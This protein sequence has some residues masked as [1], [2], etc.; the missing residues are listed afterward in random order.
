MMARRFWILLLIL[1]SVNFTGC[2][3]SKLETPSQPEI[4]LEVERRSPLEQNKEHILTSLIEDEKLREVWFYLYQKTEMFPFSKNMELCGRDLAMYVIENRIP[5]ILSDHPPCS[6]VGCSRISC[7]GEVC[8]YENKTGIKPI[9]FR[10]FGNSPDNSEFAFLV[11]TMAHEIFHRMQLFGQVDVTQFEEFLAFFVGTRVSGSIWGEFED[12]DPLQPAC[13]R[14]WFREH[15]LDFY[16]T[17]EAYP[18]LVIETL[19]EDVQNPTCSLSGDLKFTTDEFG[20]PDYQTIS[21]G[22]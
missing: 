1:L 5:I 21:P 16:L 14:R 13:L 10:S 17:L 4:E 19:N 20:L 12:Y 9:Y 8:K 7:W 11:D 22:K 3:I 6:G 2:S 15:K 18:P